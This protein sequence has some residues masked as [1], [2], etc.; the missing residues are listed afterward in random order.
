MSPLA[1][2]TRPRADSEHLASLLR[3]QGVDSLIDPVI[4]ILPLADA[5][6]PPLAPIQAFLLTSANGVRA[7]AELLGVP[8]AGR[9]KQLLA[10]GAATAEAARAAGFHHIESAGGDVQT[11]VALAAKLL[12]PT[13]GPLL[14]IAGNRLAGDLIGLLGQ[15]GFDVRRQCIYLAEASTAF[16]GI[17]RSAL[18]AGK[19]H[20]V[21]FFSPRS[22]R[23]F[24]KLINGAAL[25]SALTK[26]SAICLSKA[27][28]EEAG[29]LT[30]RN[31]RVAAEPLQAALLDEVAREIEV[32]KY[33]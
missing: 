21:L 16:T 1:L 17:T 3:V 8:P 27:V 25:E 18:V 10:V 28:A 29:E 14:H 26:V 30:W 32:A 7:L 15:Q 24:V 11:L 4:N 13:D 6:L 9:D 33:G 20:M 22:A 5:A 19:I 23:G 31:I 12:N 2:L